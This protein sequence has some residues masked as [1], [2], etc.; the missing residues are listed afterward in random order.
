MSEY[1]F[2]VEVSEGYDEAVVRTRLALRG[3]GFSII[4][5]AHVGGMLA[6]EAGEERQY[7]I[8]GAYD[9]AASSRDVDANLQVAVHLP[10]N[11]VVQESGSSAF[12]AALDPQDSA[13]KSDPSQW[14]SAAEARAALHRVLEKVA[15]P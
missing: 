15:S 3:E 14:E 13:D 4:T 7:L 5:E 6:E 10:C 8:M 12:V 9:T 1:G 11:V 2:S